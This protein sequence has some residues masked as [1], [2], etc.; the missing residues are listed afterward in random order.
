[1]SKP[2]EIA[3]KI[4][5]CK[6]YNIPEMQNLARAYLE[7]EKKHRM[8]NNAVAIASW[9]INDYVKQFAKDVIYNSKSDSEITKLKKSREGLRKALEF[10]GNWVNSPDGIIHKSDCET[11]FVHEPLEKDKN[12]IVVAGKTARE[13]INVDDELMK[14]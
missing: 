3:E 6:T 12:G 13:A 1:M 14:G 4:L 9:N 5:N 8:L 11:I 10:Y 7:L 2:K